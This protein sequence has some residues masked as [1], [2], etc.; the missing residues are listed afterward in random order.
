MQAQDLEIFNQMPFFFWVKD[1]DGR[2]IWV[3]NA[4]AELANGKIFGKTDN[5]LPWAE[6]ADKLKAADR[7]VLETGKAQFIHEYVDE[8]GRGKVTLNVCKFVGEL[9]GQRCAFGISFVIE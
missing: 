7:Q 9:D 5:E 1:R 8:S 2:Y 3:N 4:L 6:N